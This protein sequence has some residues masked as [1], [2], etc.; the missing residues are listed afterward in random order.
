MLCVDLIGPY[1]LKGKHG[2]V[3][4]FM[5][6]TMIDFATS[7]FKIA[8]LPLVHGLKIIAVNGKQA[9]IV[10]GIFDKSSDCIA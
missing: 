9:S 8:E 2:T 4:A 7:W 3:I 5:A 10:D 1:T 6:L